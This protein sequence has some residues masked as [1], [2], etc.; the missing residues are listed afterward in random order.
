MVKA[1]FDNMRS[2]KAY[3]QQFTLGIND[4]VTHTSIPIGEP[5]Q[6]TP[7]STTQC[8]FWGLG[9]DGT[10]GANRAATKT[11]ADHTDL[12]V[13]GYFSYD[14][15]KTDGTTCSHLRFGPETIQSEYM[16][17]DRADYVACHKDKYVKKFDMLAPLKDGGIFVLNSKWD[18]EQL[19]E[20]LPRDFKRQLAEK[21]VQFY[22]IDAQSI[23]EA[24]GLGGRRINSVM[25]AVFYSLSGVLPADEAVAFLKA[26]I[27]RL[28]HHKGPRIVD[29]N[30]H[31][32]DETAKHLK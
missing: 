19:E 13:Q 5:L 31:A 26:D 22:N 16:I 7:A 27:E 32:V 24:T 8:I 17:T 30:I 1:A 20:E 9:S 10:V 29:Q 25:Q 4:D 18:L 21:N 2:G 12:K 6:T 23:A 15:Y 28:Y 3:I 11:I 14:A